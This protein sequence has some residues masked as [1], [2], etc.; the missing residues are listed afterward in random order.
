VN[1]FP[2]LG[3][4]ASVTEPE[5]EPVK[6]T[7]ATV[8]KA[9][10]NRYDQSSGNG[11][12]WAFATHVRCSAGFGQGGLI[13][14]ADAV[15]MDLWPSK[16]LEIHGHEV[17]VSRSDWL[18][19][20]KDPAKCEPVKRYCDRWWLVVSDRAI[21]KPG[22]LPSD[23]GLLVVAD[24]KF[25]RWNPERRG[26]DVGVEQSVRVAVQA[27]RLKPEPISRDFVAPLLRATAKT[28]RREAAS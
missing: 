18:T 5:P 6:H 8:L 7:E 11:D 27:P 26:Y 10:R 28:A 21:V 17:K 9:L 12:R 15:A 4:P 13:R 20:L 25:S 1:L 23:W 14:T 24:R 2:D 19:E 16:G 3:V 22:E